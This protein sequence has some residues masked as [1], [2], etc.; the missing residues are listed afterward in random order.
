ML[1]GSESRFFSL[2]LFWLRRFFLNFFEFS[3]HDVSTTLWYV[4][5]SMKWEMPMY[6]RKCLCKIGNACVEY[7]IYRKCLFL[8]FRNMGNA[9][10]LYFIKGKCLLRMGISYA[11]IGKCLPRKCEIYFWKIQKKVGWH[12]LFGTWEMPMYHGHFL[13]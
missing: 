5:Y 4:Q 6:N 7:S 11:N 10:V 8:I 13:C 2:L 1:S 3:I 9:K 12:F